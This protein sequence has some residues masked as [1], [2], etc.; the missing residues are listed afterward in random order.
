MVFEL[1]QNP[2]KQKFESRLH[3]VLNKTEESFLDLLTLS[4]FNAQATS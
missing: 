2:D 4:E 1:P 3:G